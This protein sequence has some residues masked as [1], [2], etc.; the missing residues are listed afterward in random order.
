VS[1]TGYDDLACAA[2]LTPT[3]TTVHQP[4][5]KLGLLAAQSMLKESDPAHRHLEHVL[6]VDLMVRG[7]TGP[8]AVKN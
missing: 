3:L 4:A 1:V 2:L 7:S 8:P 5:R 6:D